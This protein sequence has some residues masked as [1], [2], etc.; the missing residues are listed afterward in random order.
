MQLTNIVSLVNSNLAGELLT[1][2]QMI[3]FLDQTIDEINDKLNT[4]YP[5]FS[6]FDPN[7]HPDYPD[8]NFFPDMYIRS[9]VCVGAAYYFY[10]TDEEGVNAAP[11]YQQMY[12]AALFRMERDYRP[13]NEWLK[14]E[15]AGSVSS[16][17]G[18]DITFKVIILL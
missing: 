7:E 11:M 2:N 18:F 8:Y 3:P 12:Q 9:V 10:I 4:V 13:A 15:N 5:A 17:F 14:D 1:L 16:P 6:E